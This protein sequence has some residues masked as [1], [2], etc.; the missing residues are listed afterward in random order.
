MT[1][2]KLT[3][4]GKL[5]LILPIIF[6][7]IAVFRREPYVAFSAAF[8][9]SLIFYSRFEVKNCSVE[10][11]DE[12]AGGNKTVDERF[13]IKHRILSSR[14]LKLNLSVV[15]NEEF[16]T[17]GE[18]NI[19]KE[20][21]TNT[22]F[23]YYLLP[24]SRGYHEVGEIKGWLFGPLNIYKRSFHHEIETEVI[25]Q[26]SKKAIK[27]AKT[28]SKRTYAEEFVEDPF[29]F[30][31]RSNEFEGIREFQPG[32][33]LRDIHWKSFSKFDK[34]M[35]R[36][37][38][39]VSP[40]GAQ[41]LL[42]CSPSMRRSLP[43]GTTK[44]DHS[45]YISLQILKNF[46]IQGHDIGMTA[47]DHKHVVFHQESDSKRATFKRLYNKVVD[48]PGSLKTK[49][50]SLDR[51]KGS[52]DMSEL[53]KKEQ[54]FSQKVGELISNTGREEIAGVLSAVDQMKAR[55]EKRK[56]VMIISDLEMQP[57]ATLKAVEY[58]K[59]IKNE[60][61]VIVPFSPWYELDKT[62]EEILEK[63]YEEYEELEKILN[64]LER[65][66]CMIFEVYP[67]KEGFKILE[68]KERRKT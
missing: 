59:E 47:F 13:E 44:L 17:K 9:F 37:Y 65:L 51:Y 32:D 68:E 46:E 60:V 66:G 67:E 3:K 61:W 4:R 35:T 45:V 29:A 62:D 11:E 12:I 21:E 16:E 1:E 27:K 10:F 8:L 39:R 28:Y 18:K 55:G 23:S 53:G 52:L 63:A 40:I 54:R 34:L 33:S 49:D 26:S 14:D 2:V 42:D 36:V 25:V 15:P 31:V 41:I 58:L 64:R 22:D 20:L 57:R 30:T 38:E 6:V 50:I 7:A 19:Y 5:F 48:L 43:N 56:L 24:K